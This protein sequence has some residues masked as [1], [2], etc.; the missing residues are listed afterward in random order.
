MW[1]LNFLIFNSHIP[2]SSSIGKGTKFAYGGIGVVIH[3]RAVIGENCVIGTNVTIGGKSKEFEVPNIGDETYISTGSKILG[4]VKI[5]RGSIIGANAVVV[6][7]VPE[8]TIAA[9][10][11]AT[12][13]RENIDIKDYV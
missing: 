9:G 7:D 4:N 12:I 11:P 1:G 5:G 13:I 3:S 6:K 8:K 2:C 10:V